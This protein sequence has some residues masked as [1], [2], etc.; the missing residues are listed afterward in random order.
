MTEADVGDRRPAAYRVRLDPGAA[1]RIPT[2]ATLV[3][4]ATLGLAACSDADPEDPTPD[5]AADADE[6]PSD[7]DGTAEG[8]LQ[9][10]G[11]A[12]EVPSLESLGIE[13]ADGTARGIGLV[14]PLPAG[15]EL[16][17]SSA[18]QGAM[19]ASDGG[20]EPE[21]L[22]LGVAGIEVD[23]LSG[24]EG[25]GLDEGLELI[26]GAAPQVPDRDEAV[27]LPG[28]AAARLLEYEDVPGPEEGLASSYQ[29]IML[30]D[31]GSG[32]LALFNYVALA[33]AVDRAFVERLT[34]EAGFDPDS[35]PPTP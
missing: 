12:E 20:A 33:G 1:V 15:W 32:R 8:T 4:A 23:P 2:V 35:S 18:A 17:P 29:L 28:A 21:Q 6:A 19:I 30:A 13:V 10:E 16:D 22:L 5:A 9:P 14:L 26:R 11:E 34:T 31:D 25:V 27:Q 7:P 24:F 3:L